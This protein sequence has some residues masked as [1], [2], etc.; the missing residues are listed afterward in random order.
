MLNSSKYGL[1][2]RSLAF[3]IELYRIGMQATLD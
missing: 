3:V 2:A 1:A